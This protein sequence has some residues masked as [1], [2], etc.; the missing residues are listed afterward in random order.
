MSSKR[1]EVVEEIP[2]KLYD[3]TNKITYKRL[4]FF[5]KVISSDRF[6]TLT[7]H[8][9]LNLVWILGIAGLTIFLSSSLPLG[10]VRKMLRDYECSNQ[11]HLRRKNRLEEADDEAQSK[12]END[13]RNSNSQVAEPQE[14]CRLPQLLR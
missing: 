3:E 13:P 4:R 14:H 1:E 5:G 11:R 9:I 7:S 12:G 10:R 8:H 2:E 6:I